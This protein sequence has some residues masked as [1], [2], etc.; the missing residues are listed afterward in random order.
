M[1]EGLRVGFKGETVREVT[2]ELTIASIRSELPA[3]LST[4]SMIL[5]ME[6]AAAEL[7]LPYLPEGNIS[8][9]VEVNIRHLAA[10]PGGETVTA[11]ATVRELV[12]NLIRFDVE[13]HDSVQLVG[14]GTHVRAVIDV[15]RFRRGLENRR[16]RN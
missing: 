8:V 16:K 13:V 12:G 5:L 14:E 2:H 3:V 7:M 6:T 10:T 4:P 15:D 9:G 1:L 11:R